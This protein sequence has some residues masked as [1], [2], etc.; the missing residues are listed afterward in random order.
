M[1][2]M[3]KSK[4]KG[5]LRQTEYVCAQNE[6]DAADLIRVLGEKRRDILRIEHAMNDKIAEIKQSHEDQ[7][8]PIKVEVSEIIKAVQGWAEANRDTLTKCGKTKTAKL[9][10]GEINW[11]SRP[12]K[13]T[14]RGKVKIIQTLKNLGLNR[15]IRTIE[16]VDKEAL[17]K[18][19]K[20]AAGISGITISSAG[21]DFAIL[22][23]ELEIEKE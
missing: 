7:A 20:I 11:R 9:T 6:D 1:N 8:T 22:P 3:N 16:E 13:V 2:K 12:P 4:A 5:A 21:E 19:K 15:F 17:L 18:E 14:L 23:Y 10:T